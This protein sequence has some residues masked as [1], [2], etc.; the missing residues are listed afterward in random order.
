MQSS[1]FLEHITGLPFL[2][3]RVGD[4]RHF[5]FIAGLQALMTILPTIT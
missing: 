2:R 3:H 1:S 4:Y 5:N